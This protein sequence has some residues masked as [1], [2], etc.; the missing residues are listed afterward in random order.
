MQELIK[1]AWLGWKNYTDSGKLA[2]L[3]LAALLFLWLWKSGNG[4]NPSRSKYFQ[5]VLYASILA[6]CCICPITAALLM[7]YQTQFYDYEWIWSMV[8]VTLVIA[9]AG[10]LMWTEFAGN[11]EKK[12]VVNPKTG[13]RKMN[14][15]SSVAVTALMFGILYLCGSMQTESWNTG[16]EAQKREKTAQVLEMLAEN[17]QNS[18][19]CLWAPQ[20]IMEYARA[21]DG[22]IRLPYGRNMWDKALNAYSYDVYGEA[23]QILYAWMSYVEETGGTEAA[24]ELPEENHTGAEANEK[25]EK[26]VITASECIQLAHELGVNC[27]LLPGNLPQEALTEIED[28]FGVKAERVEEF[29]LFRVV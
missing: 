11:A 26:R 8:P 12:H 14:W 13:K 21:L 2:A 15:W 3:F 28:D 27:I 17:G 7:K 19:I 20:E 24:I 1:N 6:V 16:E 9:L 22:Q 23:E 10:T 18:D 29:Y 25:A 5:I 4:K